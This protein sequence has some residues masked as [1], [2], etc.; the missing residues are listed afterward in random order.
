[1][2]LVGSTFLPNLIHMSGWLYGVVASVT[3]LS[4]LYL[5]W[6]LYTSRDTLSMKKIGR[7]LFLYSL[8]YLFVI[9]LALMVDHYAHAAGWV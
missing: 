4:F 7:Q 2:L 8:S 5:A 1:M 3:G 9:F 6:R